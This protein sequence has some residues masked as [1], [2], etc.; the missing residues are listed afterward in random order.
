MSHQKDLPLAIHHPD[1]LVD[2][3]YITEL[4]QMTDKWF[5]SLIQQERFPKPIKLGRSSR[6][7]LKDVEAW[8]SAQAN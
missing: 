6:W 3:K 1:F 7:R 4:T 2:M 5:Y 8:I